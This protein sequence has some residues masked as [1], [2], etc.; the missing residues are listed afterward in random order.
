L[1][2]RNIQQHL[3]STDLHQVK[4]LSKV[5]ICTPDQDEFQNLVGNSSFK[6]T[7]MIKFAGRSDQFFHRHEP[8]CGK[9]PYL[10]IPRSGH[11]SGKSQEAR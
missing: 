4:T 6:D 11:I 7:T 8:N 1:L 9:M 10:A 3:E 5:R 2:T